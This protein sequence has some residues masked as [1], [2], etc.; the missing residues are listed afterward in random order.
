M[1]VPNPATPHSEQASRLDG[2]EV[3][4]AGTFRGKTYTV[5]DLDDMVAAFERYSR[6]QVDPKNGKVAVP[7]VVG[8]S[9]DQRLLQDTGLPAACW[10]ERLYRRGDTLFADLVDVPP[11]FMG[12]IRTRRYRKVSAE[13]YDR[14][15]DGLPT[16]GTPKKMLRRIAFLGGEIPQ[17]KTLADIPIPHSETP[18]AAMRAARLVPERTAPGGVP[19]SYWCFS[20]V[21]QM[22]DEVKP[23]PE[24][25][26]KPAGIDRDEVMKKL[27][28][29]GLSA[30]AL[31]ECPDAALAEMLRALDAKEAEK[32]GEK[33][34]PV[35]VEEK[36]GAEPD[37]DEKKPDE[38]GE[39]SAMRKDT[40]GLVGPDSSDEK[41]AAHHAHMA[42]MYAGRCAAK[43]SE[44]EDRLAQTHK[45]LAAKFAAR[46]K[47]STRTG[48]TNMS[49]TDKRIA[50]QER[51]LAEIEKYSEARLDAERRA[52]IDAEIEAACKAGRLLASQKADRRALL[53]SLSTA[54]VVK[55]SDGGKETTTSQLDLALR[56][57]RSGPVLV[58]FSE[59]LKATGGKGAGKDG[60]RQEDDAEVAAVRA[61]YQAYSEQ[62]AGANLSED[63][64]V[65]AFEFQRKTR[66]GLTA[67]QFRQGK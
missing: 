65:N 58:R 57:L 30:D 6:P 29:H 44:E 34:D 15:P 19:G 20:E 64:L 56:E 55:F 60:G 46:A 61:N 36:G 54:K 24:G 3:F 23:A 38:M 1:S 13:V 11:E 47:T 41:M 39:E 66:P 42:S 63:D 51:R 21:E 35:E 45:R 32:E 25:E 8:H 28:E 27:Q 4:Q 49:E 31:A 14:H 26:E 59:R 18:T 17:V 22:D 52:A 62:F 53:L 9:E 48:A 37:G 50:A 2:V 10:A 7:G 33:D 40:M 16:A 12:L 43:Y 67:E 5:R